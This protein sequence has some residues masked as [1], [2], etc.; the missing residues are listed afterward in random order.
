MCPRWHLQWEWMER[1]SIQAS[2]SG[3]PLFLSRGRQSKMT[4]LTCSNKRYFKLR[5]IIEIIQHDVLWHQRSR[6][7][8]VQLRCVSQLQ[9]KHMTASTPLPG[10]AHSKERSTVYMHSARLTWRPNRTARRAA[11]QRLPFPRNEP[12]LKSNTC[13]PGPPSLTF[14]FLPGVLAGWRRCHCG[15]ELRTTLNMKSALQQ[16]PQ[17][18]KLPD[19]SESGFFLHFSQQ[20]GRKE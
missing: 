1:R 20:G 9:W 17:P 4:A 3:G 7:R 5:T 13:E 14:G 10:Q 18:D 12:R 8:E 19:L 16:P 11:E 2:E 6:P 15:R